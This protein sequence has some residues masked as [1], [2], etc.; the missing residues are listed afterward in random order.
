MKPEARLQRDVIE[1]ARRLNFLC[2]HFGSAQVR[3]GVYVTPVGG[4]GA[5]WPD[6]VLVGWHNVLYVE[7]KDRHGRL[8]DAQRRWLA[9]LE[10]AGQDVYVWR[11]ADWD[12]GVVEATL[13]RL[14]LPRRCGLCGAEMAGGLCVAH[15][16]LE[17][18]V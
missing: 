18:S 8:S 6:L 9:A 17:A 12:S 1:L 2:A 14:A 5:G 13:K 7:L 11:P 16:A 10:R 3:K 4:D 15:G